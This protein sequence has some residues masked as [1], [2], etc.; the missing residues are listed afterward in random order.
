MQL[1]AHVTSNEVFLLGMAFGV[2]MA[3]GLFVAWKLWL[4]WFHRNDQG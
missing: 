1:L 2:G 3:S 4:R